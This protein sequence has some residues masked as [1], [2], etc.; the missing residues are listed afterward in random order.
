M[1]TGTTLGLAPQ[2]HT[3]S[4]G[5]KVV[6]EHLPYV[7]SVSVGVW[8]KTG[9]ANESSEIAGIS[10]F[11]EHMF[12]KGTQTRTTR[13]I[14]EAIE[15]KGG[16]LNAFTSREY[17]CLYVK[18]L[19]QQVD[20][21]VDIL[22]DIVNYSTFGD[23]EKERNVILEEIASGIDVPDEYV[24]DLLADKFWPGHPMGRPIAGY[25]DTVSATGL[26]N[27]Q[28]YK[29]AWYCPEN[30]L[31]VVVGNFD[32]DLLLKRIEDG[33]ESVPQNPSPKG[34]GTPEF[35]SGV[36]IEPRDI[37]QNHLTL[38]FPG[39]SITQENRY[40]YDMLSSTLGGGS[41][42]RLFESIREEAGLAY[43][44]YSYNS[45]HEHTGMLGMYA[46][47]APENLQQTL[48]LISKEIKE[49]KD[50]PISD[51]ELESNREQLKGGLLLALENT[52]NRMARMARSL[53]FFNEIKT[54][55][56]ILE[57]INLV[58]ANDIQALTQRTF[59][60]DNHVMAV[61]GP[62]TE[63]EPSMSL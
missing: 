34:Y 33:F 59:N 38:A 29:D 27:I 36:L 8:I 28:T 24:H 43:S 23:L 60:M 52:F 39:T 15:S 58:D 45:A 16:H 56:E 63:S 17:T 22:S 57:G 37:A 25:H 41:T 6:F 48:D 10:H 18:A 51:K 54:V 11:L 55:D 47:I 20:T 9:S 7:H 19:D 62:A 31:V 12:F 30:M 14:M 46:A 50:T 49:L 1:E 35:G 61:L 42:S 3:L 32:S 4:N 26:E 21:A 5:M 44:I 53:M 40:T 13:E 2:L